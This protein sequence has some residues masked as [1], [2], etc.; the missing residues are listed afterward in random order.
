MDRRRYPL[1]PLAGLMG[2]TLADA[3]RHLGVSG[4]V[5]K[6]Y[7]ERGVTAKVADRLAAK[8]G[9]HP[10]VV[11]PEWL[12]DQI[13]AAEVECADEKCDQRFVPRQR[14]YRYCSPQCRQR[15]AGRASMRRR[16]ADPVRKARI[17][18]A[19]AKY[20]DEA[21][22]AL[23]AYRR[24]YYAANRERLLAEQRRRDHERRS[25]NR[26]RRTEEAA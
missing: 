10:A 21:R 5:Q 24:R 25:P 15:A 19:Q 9:F 12:D 4:S 3:C 16:R 17:D 13:A 1:E 7:R 6:E 22:R 20:Q 14:T 8:A 18:A 2:T 11:W 26:N 23:S